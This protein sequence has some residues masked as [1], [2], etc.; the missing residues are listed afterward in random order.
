MN[1][2]SGLTGLYG[3]KIMDPMKIAT[4]D[5]TGPTK[6]E[7][8]AFAAMPAKLFDERAFLN[9]DAQLQ[10]L[11]NPLVIYH[12]NCADGF[13][14][15]WVFH[16]LQDKIEQQFDFHPGVYG[17][18][19]PDV[20]D[21][22]VYLVDFS[23]KR[24][25]VKDMIQIGGALAVVVIDHHKTAMEDLAG[26]DDELYEEAKIAQAEIDGGALG[27]YDSPIE[28]VFDMDMSGATMAWKYWQEVWDREIIERP[29]L[30]GH[31]EDRDLWKFRLPL[32]REIQA[33][34]FSYEYTFEN[35]DRLMWNT[36]MLVLAEGGA[37][38]ERKH[39]KDIAELVKVCKRAMTIG[40]F[41]VPVASLPYTLTSDAG[42]LM[43]KD[44]LDGSRFAA[45]YWDTDLH[46]IFSLRSMEGGMDVSAIAKLYG[47]GGHKNAAGFKVP[48]TH[49]L[50]ML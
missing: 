46:R 7:E 32:T 1:I 3:V 10:A 21:R 12:A 50:A 29:V 40:G 28:L 30:L 11:K 17:E 36:G 31:V 25:V 5:T 18:D 26:L 8:E 23:Y 16:F 9:Q 22:H 15:A 2:F 4:I 39:R 24:S 48:R 34:V 45:C 35:W 20:S 13:S 42:H 49:E 41:D 44:Y 38:I 33:A 6:E 43:A 47:G 19:P 37:A 14:A 27:E